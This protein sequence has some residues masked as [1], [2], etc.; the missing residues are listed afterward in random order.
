MLLSAGSAHAQSQMEM[1]QQAADGFASADGE[2]NRVYREITKRLS[3]AEKTKLVKAQRLWVQF[4]DA[5]CDFESMGVDGGSAQPMIYSG[6][7]ESLT[8]E[9]TKALRDVTL[10][11]EEGNL[12]CVFPGK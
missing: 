6:C 4:R 7:L 9:R 1:N 3:A 8:R 2:L 5:E 12:S 11:C 10:D